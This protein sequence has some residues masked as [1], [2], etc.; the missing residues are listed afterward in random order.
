MAGYPTLYQLTNGFQVAAADEYGIPNNVV[1]GSSSA[2]PA[3]GAWNPPSDIGV[4]NNTAA[5]PSTGV[6]NNKANSI[7]PKEQIAKALGVDPSQ[8]ETTLLSTVQGWGL[9]IGLFLLAI[10]L[11]G[12]GGKVLLEA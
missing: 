9:G 4:P 1:G 2:T 3:A 8:L 10:V 11:I 12:V 6:P 5:D 7:A